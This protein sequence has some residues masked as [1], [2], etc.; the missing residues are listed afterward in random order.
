MPRKL[1]DRLL[2]NPNPFIS[3]TYLALYAVSLGLLDVVLDE[4][5]EFVI[6]HREEVQRVLDAQQKEREEHDAGVAAALK[7]YAVRKE[8]RKE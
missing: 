6:G 4:G 7:A 3:G 2:H 8:N 1:S 5:E